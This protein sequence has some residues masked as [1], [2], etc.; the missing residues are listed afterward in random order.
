MEPVSASI[1]GVLALGGLVLL[2]YAL[3]AD[4]P[5]GR[6]RCP[7]C[8]YRMDGIEGRRC[9]ECGKTTK[10][11]RRLFRTRRKWRW[12]A[13]AALGV[14]ASLPLAGWSRWETKGWEG[15]PGDVLVRLAWMDSQGMRDEVE[16]RLIRE[17]FD[18]RQM[19]ILLDRGLEDL[20][21]VEMRRVA[22][23]RTILDEVQGWLGTPI[24]ETL[25]KNSGGRQRIAERLVPI[26]LPIA[27][28]HCP[29][30]SILDGDEAI[31]WAAALAPY[32]DEALHVTLSS[33]PMWATSSVGH[34]LS[35][36]AADIRSFKESR[37]QHLEHTNVMRSY[38]P[39]LRDGQFTHESASAWLK[40]QPA[41]RETLL[42][43]GE[44]HLDPANAPWD[45]SYFDGHDETARRLFAAAMRLRLSEPHDRVLELI[46]LPAESPESPDAERDITD[47]L[48][49]LYH[50]P[51][52]DVHMAWVAH[53]ILHDDVPSHDIEWNI[54]DIHG[55]DA[56]AIA[57]DLIAHFERADRGAL[58]RRAETALRVMGDPAPLQDVAARRVLE[59]AHVR[60]RV[61]EPD[62]PALWDASI[63]EWIEL[64]ADPGARRLGDVLEEAVLD[65][66]SPDLPG[67]AA[68]LATGRLG[69]D[70]K[71]RLLD[72]LA[73]LSLRSAHDRVRGGAFAT[74]TYMLQSDEITADAI[75]AWLRAPE[76]D[77]ALVRAK[78]TA[79]GTSSWYDRPPGMESRRHALVVAATQLV[80]DP[81]AS[82]A[83]AAD[84]VLEEHERRR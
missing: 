41:T 84:I 9:P 15:V 82:I 63:Y 46:D 60:A 71:V 42:A 39:P 2:V 12:A 27:R 20:G 30:Q 11:E 64:V 23:A 32:S 68:L 43:Y 29:N 3:F 17:H 1:A 6:R 40:R 5:R 79:F 61:S 48:V 4:R 83:D 16:R 14:I 80:T 7:E 35:L 65:P 13:V 47:A 58:R 33:F 25:S 50:L 51:W 24:H 81:D 26:V 70:D 59:R 52:S 75:I 54:L 21:H 31:A 78:A 18:A 73:R 72:T 62:D 44:H 37:T 56:A 19:D 57:P 28:G 76:P 69:H 34:G 38:Y 49:L 55:S 10:S 67:A 74:L 45:A 53:A 36:V 66:V 8:A 77:Q 22:F